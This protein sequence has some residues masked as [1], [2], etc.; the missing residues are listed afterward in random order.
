MQEEKKQEQVGEDRERAQDGL[1]GPRGSTGVS[2]ELGL[3]LSKHRQEAARVVGS[4]ARA[5]KTWQT[6]G[7]DP[8]VVEILKEGASVAPLGEEEFK[9]IRTT[10]VQEELTKEVKKLVECG[11]VTEIPYSGQRKTC[12]L[13]MI[14]KRDQSWRVIHDLQAV[15]AY[16]ERRRFRLRGLQEIQETLPRG[17]QMITLDLKSGYYQVRVKESH[18]QRVTFEYDRRQYSWV[19]LPFGLNTAPETFQAVTRQAAK[20]IR[21]KFSLGVTVYLDDLL[22]WGS[23]Q[24]LL[25]ARVA[26][27]DYLMDLGMVVSV[28]KSVLIPSQQVTYLGVIIDSERMTMRLTADKQAEYRQLCA[29]T[30]RDKHHLRRD[31][32]RL[33]GKL[34]F[35]RFAVGPRALVRLRELQVAISSATGPR[36]KPKES[37]ESQKQWDRVRTDLKWWQEMWFRRVEYS[38]EPPQ[39]MT[40]METDAS[41]AAFGAVLF[42]PGGPLTYQGYFSEAQTP[43][44]I[45]IKELLAI[46][47]ALRHFEQQI[48]GR[49]VLL[50]GDNTTSLA[51]VARNSTHA[52]ARS[53]AE[54]RA[55]HDW[56]AAR[57]VRLRT[58]HI[59]GRYNTTAD[60]LSRF[61][62]LEW[63]CP[64]ALLGKAIARWGGL[65][66]ALFASDRFVPEDRDYQTDAWT[67]DWTR[68]RSLAIPKTRKNF[69]KGYRGIKPTSQYI[70][71]YY[72]HCLPCRRPGLQQSGTSNAVQHRVYGHLCWRICPCK[73]SVKAL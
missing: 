53:R 26:L 62:A 2:P 59:P 65:D 67:A 37:I 4:M 73:K 16:Q 38:F 34:L 72:R 20:L 49:T 29:R 3:C 46:V 8:R 21:A 66:R 41:D 68:G 50:A 17:A 57:G 58:K 7:A 71:T 28:D 45:N 55:I 61:T 36:L 5:W 31:L 63:D 42:T 30:L 32:Q 60:G 1:D 47:F 56:M 25:E 11:A 51:W 52:P 54:V 10:D 18:R 69:Y 13:F 27:L 14:T 24:D 15:N 64:A 48:R 9:Q 33:A 23:Y 39:V 44:H 40:R 22:L 6:E 70:N 35:A 12:P 43:L 19:A